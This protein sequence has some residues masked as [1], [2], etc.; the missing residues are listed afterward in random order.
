MRR[1]I[2]IASLL[3]C[4]FP[5]LTQADSKLQYA[6]FYAD[7][8][9]GQF[10]RELGQGK[11]VLESP[12]YAKLLAARIYLEQ[13]EHDVVVKKDKVFSGK[14]ELNAITALGYSR[15]VAD[16]NDI[17]QEIQFQKSWQGL[18]KSSSALKVYPSNGRDGNIAGSSYPQGV[19]SLTFDDGPEEEMTNSIL[20]ELHHYGY[21][22]SFFVL[23]R[24][25]NLFPDSLNRII[26][27]GHELALHSYNHKNLNLVDQKT[28][29]YEVTQALKE[30]ERKSLAAVKLFRLPYGSGLHNDSLR[31]VITRNK[32]IHVFWN[33]DTLDWKDKDP[34]SI[35]KRAVQQM[36]QTPNKSGII[37]FHDIHP[38]TI[39]AS[40]MIMDYLDKKKSK[41][42]LVGSVVDHLNGLEQ[43][44]LK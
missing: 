17:G 21:K 5:S 8:L 27:E 7:Q 26:Q 36:D 30:L 29:E 19:W 43:D 11:N 13:E 42:C 2:L 10:D 40:K 37:L 12:V 3:L 6:H 1:K 38:Q 16:I 22:A 28:T 34:E 9:V 35:F 20:D 4:Y 15:V 39:Q 25:A 33:V 24:Q 23:L 31:S 32:L 14:L 44:C 41:V 18:L